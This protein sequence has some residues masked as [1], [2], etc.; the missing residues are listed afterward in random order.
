M[1]QRRP[2]D[3]NDANELLQPCV[4]D[5]VRGVQREALRDRGGCDHQIGDPRAW[6]AA[7]GNDGGSHPPIYPGRLGVERDRVELALGA[8]QGLGAAGAFLVLVV[9]V[10]LAVGADLMRTGGQF[11]QGDRADCHL[12]R[13]FRWVNPAAQDQ[14]VGVEQALPGRFA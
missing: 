8:L 2:R 13:E 3:G 10:L 4:V 12:I 5:W 1:G 7:R 6:L 14:N 11:G 9:Q